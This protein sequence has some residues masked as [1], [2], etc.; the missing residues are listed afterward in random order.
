MVG[1]FGNAGARRLP[2]TPSAVMRPLLMCCKTPGMVGN[3]NETWPESRSAVVWP[4]TLY[5]I[6]VN[7]MPA[8]LR[9]SS[10]ARWPELP[11][12]VEA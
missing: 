11:L 12:P 9:K 4:I 7:S 3:H 5:G 2:E 10:I 1:T 6:C 8:M